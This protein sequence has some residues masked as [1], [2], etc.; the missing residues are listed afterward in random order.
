M[1][2]F[3]F[4]PYDATGSTGFLDPALAYQAQ[5][6]LLQPQ[7]P[8]MQAQAPVMPAPQ[9]QAASAL[10]GWNADSSI[11]TSLM[12][13]GAGLA[14][15]GAPGG[16]GWGAGIGKG[17]VEGANLTE[18]ARS[19]RLREL[20]LQNQIAYQNAT[21]GQGQQTLDLNKMTRTDQLNMQRAQFAGPINLVKSSLPQYDAARKAVIEGRQ[22]T[23]FGPS[24]GVFSN[25]ILGYA[26]ATGQDPK[27]LMDTMLPQPSDGQDTR[28]SKVQMMDAAVKELGPI[29]EQNGLGAAQDFNIE[30]LA[31]PGSTNVPKGG[32][33]QA[34]TIPGAVEGPNA[35]P[36]PTPDK[37]QILRQYA[38]NPEAIKAFD[39]I[40]G[41]GAADHFLQGGR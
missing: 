1:G 29:A 27:T 31:A 6:S 10:P 24:R 36:I 12:G 28:Y 39:E 8:A 4:P 25:L 9:Q 37:L 41:A 19:D 18:R 32:A 7:Q 5:A 21:L 23:Y 17:L 11:W 20:T 34:G 3:N 2:L 15:G 13:L 35:R 26:K 38:N 22:N 30:P 16:G 33:V 14:A 40:Y